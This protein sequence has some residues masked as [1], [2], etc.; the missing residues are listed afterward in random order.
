MTVGLGEGHEIQSRQHAEALGA[1]HRHGRHE[2][3]NTEEIE[4]TV[5]QEIPHDPES[6]LSDLYC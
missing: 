6:G 4:V 1:Q 5:L 2:P 3:A